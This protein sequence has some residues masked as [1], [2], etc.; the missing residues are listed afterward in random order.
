MRFSLSA[1]ALLLL[2]ACVSPQAASAQKQDATYA[3]CI[4]DTTRKAPFVSPRIME[5]GVIVHET[6]K[7]AMEDV[8]GCCASDEASKQVIL[9]QVIGSLPQMS[10]EQ[11][12]QI[13]LAAQQAWNGGSGVWP[14]MSLGERVAAVEE[15]LEELKKQREAIIEVLMWEIGKNEKDAASEFDRTIQ[16]AQQ[17]IEVVK[18]DPEFGTTSWQSIGATRAFVRRAAVGIILCLGPYNYPLNETYATLIPALLMGNIIVL[19]IPTVGGLSHLL[20]MDA[21]S[22]ALP[23][24]TIHFVSGRGRATMPPLMKTGL[25][26][27]LAFIGG[28]NA[29]DTLI[30]DHPHPHRLKVFL[31]LEANNMGVRLCTMDKMCFGSFIVAHT[32]L[33]PRLMY[34]S[35]WRMCSK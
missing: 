17:V 26:D 19:K 30:K 16:F 12:L 3:T 14:Q 35:S 18:S 23:P 20:T 10:T 34:R 2:L 21:F 15:F 6:E 29:A 28:S 22:K 33:I 9:P 5:N 4:A 13:A 32:F 8:L 27:G 7:M 31:Q 25:I 1:V 11:T 24:G